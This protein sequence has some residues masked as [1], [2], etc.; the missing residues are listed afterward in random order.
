MYASR[1]YKS[2]RQHDD[3]VTPKRITLQVCS[4]TNVFGTLSI[5][6]DSG[7]GLAADEL[8]RIEIEEYRTR[9]AKVAELTRLAVDPEFGSKEVLG[10]LFHVAY[11]FLGPI[12]NVSDVF[13]EVNP[14]HVVFYRRMLHFRQASEC[15]MCPRV[16]APAVL[17]HVEVKHVS[18]QA[19]M[20]GGAARQSRTLFPYF[21]S[22]E[23]ERDVLNRVVSL[24]S[25]A[26]QA[27]ISH[28]MVSH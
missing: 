16:S 18:E 24:D 2:S 13:I 28:T 20:Y 11:T 19:A 15:K 3:S 1:G 7:A 12:G 9:G 6:F 22:S 17:L 4:P 14:R 26:E 21:C 10:A 23:E 27:S 8:Y 25:R 5:C